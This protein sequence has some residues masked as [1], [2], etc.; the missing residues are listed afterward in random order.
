MLLETGVAGAMTGDF[1]VSDERLGSVLSSECAGVRATPERKFLPAVARASFEQLTTLLAN[2]ERFRIAY[3]VKTNPRNEILELAHSLGLH[4]EVISPHE[5]EHVRRRGFEPNAILYNGPWPV[6]ELD[7]A[8]A[9]ADSI[10]AFA[11]NCERSFPTAHGVRLRPDGVTSRFGV[12]S[13][14]SERLVELIGN[15]SKIA[16]LAVS[17][18]VRSQDLGRRTWSAVAQEIIQRAAALQTRTGKPIVAVDLGGGCSPREFD[19]RVS[20]DYPKIAKLAAAALPK[21]RDVFIEPGQE[22]ATAL[23][24]LIVRVLEVRRRPRGTDIVVDS[25]LPA[26]P[27]IVDRPHRV[28]VNRQNRWLKLA[29]GN[30]RILGNICMED[31]V[32][33]SDVALPEN[34][35][36]GDVLVIADVGAYDSSMAFGFAG[37]RQPRHFP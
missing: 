7:V 15:S 24:V 6:G 8:I 13:G 9:F 11:R 21:L 33:H 23:E 3:S 18:F 36:E 19:D 1:C 12:P 26:M 28:F 20:E 32:V 4:V 25:G 5:F 35:A 14:E 31:D 34:I 29:S 22:L 10:E 16:A 37:G 17:F 30:D 27:H 2:F